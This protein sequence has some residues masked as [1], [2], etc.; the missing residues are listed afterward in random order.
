LRRKSGCCSAGV[1]WR[2]RKVYPV[3]MRTGRT[4]ITRSVGDGGGDMPTEFTLEEF[5]KQLR[6]LRGMKVRTDP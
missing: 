6:Q 3:I 4:I 2:R 5:A 1:I